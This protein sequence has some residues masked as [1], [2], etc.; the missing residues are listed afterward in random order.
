MVRIVEHTVDAVGCTVVS[1][2]QVVK[3]FNFVFD[4]INSIVNHILDL[5]VDL[6]CYTVECFL[7]LIVDLALK[8]LHCFF[9]C[10]ADAIF[11]SV[12]LTVEGIFNLLDEC[13]E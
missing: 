12:F 10:V 3:W 13:I 11:P 8:I 7:N 4:I 9:E 1:V 6:T 2:N 5:V